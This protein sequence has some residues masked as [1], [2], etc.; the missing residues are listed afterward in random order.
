MQSRYLSATNKAE[1]VVEE[2][3]KLP[4][5]YHYA[6]MYVGVVSFGNT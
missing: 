5:L 3:F 4:L 6:H 2:K 1:Y